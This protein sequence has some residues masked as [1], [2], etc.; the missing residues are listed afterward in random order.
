MNVVDTRRHL[1][2]MRKLWR[3]SGADTPF[4][5][6]TILDVASELPAPIS[7]SE[8]SFRFVRSHH[9]QRPSR[10]P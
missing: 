6:S 3:S 10:A 5:C 7:A 9:R 2:E 8:F 4:Y 1:N